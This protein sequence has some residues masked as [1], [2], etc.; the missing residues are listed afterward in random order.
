MLGV[1]VVSR[2]V[3]IHLSHL[4][5]NNLG[6]E[7]LLQGNFSVVHL[8][9]LVTEFLGLILAESNVGNLAV[10][11]RMGESS[12]DAPPSSDV[13]W[14]VEFLST[15]RPLIVLELLKAFFFFR[16]PKRCRRG[17]SPVGVITSCVWNDGY[18]LVPRPDPRS[19]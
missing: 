8:G 10:A 16:C 12:K 5:P 14:P 3:Y 4:E 18:V 13:K 9:P 1:A 2:G 19:V 6:N 17:G 11:A 7:P 15:Y